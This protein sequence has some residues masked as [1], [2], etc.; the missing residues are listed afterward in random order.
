VTHDDY[1]CYGITSNSAQYLNG[2]LK[3]AI[4]IIG[5]LVGILIGFP[6]FA[7]AVVIVRMVDGVPPI[8]SQARVGLHGKPFVI[9]KLRTLPI[10]ITHE[11]IN[12]DHIS[13]KPKYATTLTGRFW[14]KTSIDEIIQFWLVLKGDMSLIGHRPFPI[15]YLPH[16]SELDG[17]D[18]ASVE[19]YLNTIY[20]FKP[21][22]SSLSAIHGRG[23]LTMQE[24]FRYDLIYASKASFW[25]DLKLLFQTIFVVITCR[26]AR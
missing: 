2:N 23:N 25:Y 5:A 9:F 22:M 12:A 20:Q 26:G 6:T 21:G 24:K 1:L 15:H 7:L 19:H 14:R 16:L 4:D 13:K 8:F 3:R 18:R 10:Q 11:T 17:L